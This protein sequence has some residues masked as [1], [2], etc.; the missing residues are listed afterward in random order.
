[1]AHQLLLLVKSLSFPKSTHACEDTPSLL[2][3]Q[4]TATRTASCDC[5][6]SSSISTAWG[7][8][9]KVNWCS[10]VCTN[11][12]QTR[13]PEPRSSAKSSGMLRGTDINVCQGGRRGCARCIDRREGNERGLRRWNGPFTLS[14]AGAPLPRV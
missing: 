6:Y 3:N 12:S 9:G 8:L 1:M 5:Y 11:Q 14:S 7:A 10:Y 4:S 2:T 13:Q